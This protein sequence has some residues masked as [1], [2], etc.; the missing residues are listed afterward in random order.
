[1]STA[2]ILIVQTRSKPRDATVLCVRGK[3]MLKLVDVETLL[4]KIPLS[5]V[6]FGFEIKLRKCKLS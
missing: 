2:N 3:L 6:A 1:M 4:C 5:L